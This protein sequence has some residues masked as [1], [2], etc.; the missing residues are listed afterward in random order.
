MTSRRLRKLLTAVST[1]ILLTAATPALQA[2][3]ILINE[4][5]SDTPGADAA[6]FVELFGPP[7]T[8]L[9]GLVVVFFNGSAGD[10][11]YAA[12][13]LDGRTTDAN[14][15]FVLGNTAVANVDLV[16]AGNLLQNGADAV[17]L[18]QAD[19]AD[20]PNG[21]TVTTT[22]L[23]DA[24]V[25]GT[26]DP[27]DAGLLV[28]L[29]P[30]QPQVD[31]N[32][33][34]A[35]ATE[36]SQRCPNGE[37]GLRNTDTYVQAAPTPG[38]TNVNV[39][40]TETA[41]IP[42]IQ[43]SGA[44][45]PFA[46]QNV[47][48][49]DVVV[50]CVAA[51]GFF[52]QDPVGDGNPATSDGVFVFTDSAPTVDVGDQVDVTG[53]VE[54]FFDHTEIASSAI[55]IDASGLPLPTPF[56]FDGSNPNPG[57]FTVP[58]LERFE[59]LRVRLQNGVTTGASDQFGDVRVAV[60][61]ARKFRETGIEF[62]GLPGL[63]VWD[64]NQEIF[65]IDPDGL[66]LP[67]VALRA[68]T[69]VT[70]A[71][72]CL[73][74]AFGNYLL[75]PS[76]ATYGTPPTLP[77]PVRNRVAGELILGSLNCLRFFDDVDDPGPQDDG[78][79]AD[80]LD[81]QTRLEKF[82]RYVRQVLRAPDILAVQEVEKIGVL[83]DLADRIATDDPSLVYTSY[84]TE[85][86]DVGG[87]D[88]GFMVRNTVS[89]QSVT[90]LGAAET[91]SVDGS[92]LH[93]RPPLQ[94]AATYLGNGA[95]FPIVVMNNHTRSLN[96]IDDPTAG[97]RVR[98][99][100]LEQAQSIAAKVQSFQTANPTTPFVVMGDL[101]AFEF[102]DGYVDVVGQI[103]GDFNPANNERSGPDLVNPNLV[104]QTLLVPAAQRYS[105]IFEGTSQTLDHALL[106][107]A[108][109]PFVRG[110]ERG[111]GNADAPASLELDAS[112]LLRVSDHDGFALFVMTDRDADGVAD[113]TD[114]CP[115][116]A[117][118]DQAD[119]DMDG[120]GNVC[121]PDFMEEIFADGFETGNT[122]AWSATVP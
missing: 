105:F 52:I 36:S 104:I 106:Q 73:S 54:E 107:T 11:S 79:V 57:P 10:T 108:L 3:E 82:S 99:K 44:A 120:I 77:V 16:F 29:N 24:I 64:G 93:D 56:L 34:G 12:F 112:S 118:P 21:T 115:D 31:E 68:L 80:P 42:E 91:L 110:L 81:Y 86:N 22:D 75:L 94:L 119:Q 20:F 15:F 85:G 48:V 33:G 96:S 43:G 76:A 7:S 63:P 1:A 39:C 27:D 102:T 58:D 60:G 111:R 90:Q 122:S 53:Q 26:S 121:D 2:G 83:E 117:N 65:E 113:D 74:Y 49:E 14:G 25:Y 61:S 84:L 62:P 19:A 5:D 114:N 89:V 92:L 23:V 98:Q 40:A 95:P 35:G 67:D 4:V 28:L 55:Q 109:V 41:T 88:V 47:M 69:P 37:G 17:A 70:S 101:N 6:E 51:N 78:A 46:D 8:S 103:A 45:S 116:D 50:T 32:S 100:R 87:I 59:G 9:T 71:E 18:Y 30:G 97:P 38:T 13:D 66:G 72:G